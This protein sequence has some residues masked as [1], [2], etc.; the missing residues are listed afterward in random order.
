M[1]IVADESLKGFRADIVA[2]KALPNLSRSYIKNL[3]IGGQI[4]VSGQAAKS[5][6]KLRPGDVI[7]IDYDPVSS[8]KIEDI[9]LP[10]LYQDDDVLVINK[11]AGVISHS[12][13]RYWYEPS[14]ASFIRQVTNQAGE[15]AGIVH[16]LDR[17]TSGVMVCAKTESALSFLQK[18][19]AA[20]K[21]IKTYRAIISGRITEPEAIIDMPIER[22]PKQPQTFRV[23]ANGKPAQ[24]KYRVI[25]EFDSYQKLELEPLTGRTHQLRVHLKQLGHPIVGD[26]LYAGEVYK[27]LLLHAQKIS[28]VLPSGKNKSFNAPEPEEFKLFEALHV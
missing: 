14:V 1:R 18:Q 5:G 12:R 2:A 28:F 24:T 7:E 16:R 10:I 13:G 15:R 9:D 17:A 8:Q 23:G 26:N 25:S 22:S 20:R 11:P 3:F 21:V 4:L 6:H 19:F 27:R